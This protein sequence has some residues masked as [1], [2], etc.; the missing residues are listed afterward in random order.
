[1]WPQ[2]YGMALLC[3]VGFTMSLF[4]GD[5]AFADPAHESGVKIGVL[6]GSGASALAGWL[7]LRF[8]G[9]KKEAT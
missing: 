4:I 5:L 8:A 2:I 3:G 1:S 7:V 9:I 6:M